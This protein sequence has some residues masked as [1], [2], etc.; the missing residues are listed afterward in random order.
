[1]LD[2]MSYSLFISSLAT[3]RATRQIKFCA[4][5]CI[6]WGEAA[7]GDDNAQNKTFPHFLTFLL[8]R[9]SMDCKCCDFV[10]LVGLVTASVRV[11]R[12]YV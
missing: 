8:E 11:W 2:D 12:V 9:L 7:C 4:A 3:N 5:A 10:M 6:R 1:M